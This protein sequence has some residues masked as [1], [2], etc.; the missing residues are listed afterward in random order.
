MSSVLV[1]CMR[2]WVTSSHSIWVTPIWPVALGPMAHPMIPPGPWLVGLEVCSYW[3]SRWRCKL[4]KSR[5]C[6]SGC[7]CTLTKHT[8]H[9]YHHRTALLFARYWMWGQEVQGCAQEHAVC[10]PYNRQHGTSEFMPIFQPDVWESM[11]CCHLLP[12]RWLVNCLNGNKRSK[13][14]KSY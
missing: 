1:Q 6:S 9:Y 14:I 3:R 10:S 4:A 5:V 8:L 11:G 2:L 13:W 12:L 7:R